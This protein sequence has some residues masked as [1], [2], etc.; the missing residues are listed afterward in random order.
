MY[1]LGGK[2]PPPPIESNTSMPLSC[3]PETVDCSDA[4]S[5]VAVPLESTTNVSFHW[6][7]EGR[8]WKLLMMQVVKPELYS[9][10]KSPLPPYMIRLFAMFLSFQNGIWFRRFAAGV[11]KLSPLHRGSN[12]GRGPAAVRREAEGNS[13]RTSDCLHT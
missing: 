6:M 1:W 7:P 2:A 10:V 9:D 3:R 4:M 11:S 8:M 5:D 12:P 13:G